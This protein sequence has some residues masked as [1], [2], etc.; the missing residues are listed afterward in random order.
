MRHE[1]N[2]SL[3]PKCQTIVFFT[4]QKIVFISKLFENWEKKLEMIAKIY[5]DPIRK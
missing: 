5:T 3:Y 2:R 4:S 1:L